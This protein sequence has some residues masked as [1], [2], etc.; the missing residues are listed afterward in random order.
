[1]GKKQNGDYEKSRLGKTSLER[2]KLL[3]SILKRRWVRK[4]KKKVT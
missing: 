4:Q 2:Q 3:F 1:M